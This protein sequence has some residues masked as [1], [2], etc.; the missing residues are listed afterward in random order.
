[1]SYSDLSSDVI[2]RILRYLPPYRNLVRMRL[3]NRATNT[4]MKKYRS[5]WVDILVK[6]GPKR[7]GPHSKHGSSFQATC[8]KNAQG[9]CRLASHY[10]RR[11]MIPVYND[12]DKFGAYTAVMKWLFKK[13]KNSASAT[14][15]RQLTQANAYKQLAHDVELQ[16]RKTE[17]KI[18]SL[19]RIKY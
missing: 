3:L 11:E 19:K 13:A 5:Y 12:T 9:Q 1:M 17:E 4:A 14:L 2:G 6:Y 18:K 16:A 15:K 7:I 10:S 8:R